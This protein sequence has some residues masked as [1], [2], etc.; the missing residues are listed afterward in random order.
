MAVRLLEFLLLGVLLLFGNLSSLQADQSYTMPLLG[1]RWA[2][3][4]ITVQVPTSPALLHNATISAME[5]WN[6]GQLWFTQAYF[7]GA[8]TYTFSLSSNGAVAVEFLDMSNETSVGEAQLMPWPLSGKV[9]EGAIVKLP[10]AFGGANFTSPLYASWLTALAI[11]ELGHV[12]GLGHP[13]I[14]DIM[15]GTA[16]SFF[17]STLDLYA[18]HVLA[19]GQV[20]DSTTLPSNIPYTYAPGS[21]IPEFPKSSVLMLSFAIAFSVLFIRL[22][23]RD[24]P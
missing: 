16:N 7:T 14:P 4:I 6:S 9:I 2:S 8:P 11:H 17:L 20:P 19:D 24:L 13:K 1:G 15:N 22:R 23:K 18:V 10:T 21:V 5:S 3:F 12:L